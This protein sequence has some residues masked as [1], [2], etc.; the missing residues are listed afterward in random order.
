WVLGRAAE[1]WGAERAAR[2]L[3]KFYPWYL[4]RLGVSGAQSH[5][6]QTTSSLAEVRELLAELR[7]RLASPV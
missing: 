2:N 5:A 3:R 1:H 6:F 4:E 7:E